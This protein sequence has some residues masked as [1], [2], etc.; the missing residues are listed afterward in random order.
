M[1]ITEADGY[2]DL[3]MW[4]DACEA[5]DALPVEVRTVPRALRVRLRCCPPLGAWGLGEHVA[6]LLRDGNRF[7]RACSA[8]FYHANARRLLQAGDR[9]GAGEMIKVA[10]ETFP[11]CRRLMLLDAQLVAEVV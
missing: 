10:V 9:K 7:D 11:E 8:G 4:G 1:S 6:G 2:A 3:G 5:L